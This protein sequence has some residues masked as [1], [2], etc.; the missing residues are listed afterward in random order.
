[1]HSD[2]LAATLRVTLQLGQ[3]IERVCTTQL[4][5]VDQANEQV[6]RLG[7]VQSPIKQRILAVQDR[8]VQCYFAKIIV[9]SRKDTV[10]RLG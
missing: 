7:P 8:P 4:A 6:A 9:H 10:Y 3:V 5:R 2:G 1:M